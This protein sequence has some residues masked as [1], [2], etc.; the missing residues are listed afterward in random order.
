MQAK[1]ESKLSL[2]YLKS[3]SPPFGI[4]KF[5]VYEAYFILIKNAKKR[6]AK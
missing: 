6:L 2:A 1:Q 5:P 3:E 4:R